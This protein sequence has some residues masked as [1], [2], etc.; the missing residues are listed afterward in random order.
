MAPVKNPHTTNK[1]AVNN[2][3]VVHSNITNSPSAV[4]NAT[5]AANNASH[6]ATGQR[7]QTGTVP[8]SSTKSTINANTIGIG[9][10]QQQ[11]QNG[12]KPLLQPTGVAQIANRSSP[13][14]I[15]A[16]IQHQQ[17]QQ[18]QHM[19]SHQQ[20][21]NTEIVAPIRRELKDLNVRYLLTL[22]KSY[23]YVPIISSIW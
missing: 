19:R 15:V 21:K 2:N 7:K 6:A 14:N 20:H 1:N 4:Q 11:Q 5:T 17:Q 8:K 12:Q 3:T 13:L 9:S 18:Q 23:M 16:S 10:Q 22:Y